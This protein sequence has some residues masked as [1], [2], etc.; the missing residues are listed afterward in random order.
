MLPATWPSRRP[1]GFHRM[2]SSFTSIPRFYFSR[3][4]LEVKFP[5]DRSQPEGNFHLLP[6]VSLSSAPLDADAMD[7]PRDRRRVAEDVRRP[8]GV[9]GSTVAGR[10][11]G[12]ARSVRVEL[13]LVEDGEVVGLD[14]A[15][16]YFVAHFSLPGQACRS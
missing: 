4:F 15:E 11:G 10:E 13:V 3:F 1:N 2:D 8:M 7:R 16:S 6:L 14:V 9:E 5:G 12:H